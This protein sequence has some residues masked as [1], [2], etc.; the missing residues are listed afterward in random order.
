MKFLPFVLKHLRRNW[1]RTGSTVVAM[2]LCVF[3]FCTLQ[4][5]LGQFDRFIDARSPRRLVTRNSIGLLSSLPLAH[6]ERMKT[7]PG[8]THVAATLMFGGVLPARKEGRS[9]AGSG[10]DWTS[11]FP[12]TAVDAE[13]YFAMQ[14]ELA[15]PPDQFRAFM[16]DLRG[17]VI[18]RALAEK[19]G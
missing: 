17:C 6:G 4:S 11:A 15:I 2:A 10:T 8:V 12:N 18:G 7:V 1:I 16:D 14:P 3:L 9:D 19:F 13:P 5:V